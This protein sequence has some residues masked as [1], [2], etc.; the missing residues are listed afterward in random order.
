MS[1]TEI[2]RKPGYQVKRVGDLLPGTVFLL[3]NEFMITS[4]EECD[5]DDDVTFLK[6]LKIPKGMIMTVSV[7]YEVQVVPFKFVEV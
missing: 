7:N 1:I 6:C 2:V 3:N 5:L 4:D